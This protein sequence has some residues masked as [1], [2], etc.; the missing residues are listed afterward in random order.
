MLNTGFSS[1]TP[2]FHACSVSKRLFM[3]HTEAC[4]TIQSKFLF[5]VRYCT[6]IMT[7]CKVLADCSCQLFRLLVNN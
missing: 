5:S 3:L 2:G 1:G 6:L 4:N 7:R